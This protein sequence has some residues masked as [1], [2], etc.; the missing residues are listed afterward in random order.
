MNTAH[1]NTGPIEELNPL[2]PVPST[3]VIGRRV[4]SGMVLLDPDFDTPE[5]EVDHRMK[6]ARNS[7]TARFLVFN[8]ETRSYQEV[9]VFANTAIKVMAAA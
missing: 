7:G 2:E 4:Q 5:C 1:I 8:F 6:A 9:E 3:T